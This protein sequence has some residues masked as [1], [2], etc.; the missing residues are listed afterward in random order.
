MTRRQNR[1]F[2]RKEKINKSIFRFTNRSAMQNIKFEKTLL[3]AKQHV[4][5][6]SKAKLSDYE[7]IL[8]A[9]G[10]KFIP[11]PKIQNAKVQLLKDFTEFSRKMRC[12]FLFHETSN[13]LHPFYTKTG[14]EPAFSCHTLENYIS[15]TKL[16][17]SYLPVR[18]FHDNITKT[19]RDSIVS[20]KQNKNII[21]KKADK[22]GNIV[23]L[24]KENYL[25]EGYRQLNSNHYKHITSHNLENIRTQ[26][27]QYI[28]NMVI[29]DALD[30][31]TYKFLREGLDNA[32]RPG[33]I[34]FLPKI[35]KLNT[36]TVNQIINDGFNSS[37]AMPPGRPIISQSGSFT[38]NIGHYIDHFLIPIVLEQHTYIKD[39]TAFINLIE[40]IRPKK[41]CLLVTY[42][43]T[44]MFTNCPINEL[45]SAVEKAY[46]E[47]DKNKY[48]I[49]SPPTEDLIF[50]L[51]TILENNVFE[52]NDDLYI[53]KIGTAIGSVPSP[54]I[55]DILMF[56]IIEEITNRFSHKQNILY[57]GR[58][59]DDGFIIYHGSSKEIHSFF[60]IANS[61]HRFVKFTFNVSS[62]TADFLDVHIFKGNRF[63]EQNV[64]DIKTYFKP[65]N[66]FLYLQRNSCHNKHVFRGFI[67]GETIRHIRN[68]NNTEDLM[69]ILHNFKEKL[70]ERGYRKSDIEDS[71][72]EAL[73]QKREIFL[74]KRKKTHIPLILGTQYNPRLR[75]I[76]KYILKHWHL[77]SFNETCRM[78]FQQKPIIAYRK[79]KNLGEIL[80]S[81]K[82]K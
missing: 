74:N 63:S 31:T 70:V 76:K 23:I 81:A 38:K 24:D 82:I 68:T 19:E 17:L 56:D 7:Y 21:I 51:R 50:L 61:F 44:N 54:E 33:R 65:T 42:D 4:I 36:E 62:T 47:F 39:T 22:N 60:D 57:S 40:S 79:H 53:Q 77:L 6:L 18:K 32:A 5:N 46:T 26:L 34:Y 41:D 28:R 29:N 2:R 15:L 1:R 69:N 73:N 55:C 3:K 49:K 20:L 71:M 35:H 75:K 72:I 11:N 66:S 67:K 27:K 12:R 78:I 58:Y 13:D 30:E 25:S 37:Q 52:F 43:V 80:T 8:L 14:F 16:E 48:D 10:L 64:L 9:R 59:R 45:L